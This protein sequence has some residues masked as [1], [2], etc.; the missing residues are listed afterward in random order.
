MNYIHG[1]INGEYKLELTNHAEQR[2]IERFRSLGIKL[3]DKGCIEL[4]TAGITEVLSNTFMYRYMNNIMTH[5]NHDIDVLLYDTV[6]KMVY[7]LVLK[8]HKDSVIVKTLGTSHDG[9]E[10][11]YYNKKNQRICWIHKDAFVFS[12]INGNVTW[13]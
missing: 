3:D 4:A 6:N 8:P 10:W 5:K 2:A 11:E 12:T 1:Y 9:S 13:I 7:A